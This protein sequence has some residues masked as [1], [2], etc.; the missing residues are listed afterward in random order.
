MVFTA[1]VCSFNC[2]HV[3]ISKTLV[4]VVCDILN[5]KYKKK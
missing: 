5:A 4:P 3:A 1:A 2:V